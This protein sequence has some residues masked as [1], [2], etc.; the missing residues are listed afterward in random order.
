MKIIGPM[1]ANNL[2]YLS[3][4]TTMVTAYLVLSE[5]ITLTACLGCALILIGIA[6]TDSGL[7]KKD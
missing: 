5:R 1:R 4:V 6:A 3:P 2:L 7:Q